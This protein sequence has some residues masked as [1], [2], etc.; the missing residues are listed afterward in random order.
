MDT[1]LQINQGNA[2]RLC[3]SKASAVATL[4]RAGIDTATARRAVRAAL[5]SP[6]TAN[7][8]GSVVLTGKGT[9]AE[10]VAAGATI[11]GIDN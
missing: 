6:F 1:I 2:K 3:A 11:P 10:R 7:H 4:K 5:A 8:L 9:Y